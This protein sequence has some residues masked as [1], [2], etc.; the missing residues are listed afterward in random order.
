MKLQKSKSANINYL[1]K[2]VL[3]D[4]FLPHPNPEYTK[5]KRAIVD[6]FSIIVS[7]D[8]E[9]GFYVYFP[10]LSQINPDLL[11]YLS[12]YKDK[13]LNKN[14]EKTGFFEQNGR[15]KAIKLGGSPSEGFL[16][17]LQD[18]KNWIMDSVSV[19]LKD[20]EL[21]QEFDEAEH[22]GKHFWISKKYVVAQN[23][24]KNSIEE[25]KN[26]RNNKLKRFNKLIDG[27]FRFHYDTVLYRKEPYAI[28]PSDLIHIS[29]KW[30]GTSLIAS[31]IL[32]KHPRTWKDKLIM[33]IAEL[34]RVKNSMYTLPDSYPVY[35]YVYSSRTVI[36]NSNINLGV[37]EGFYNVD[38]WKYGFESLKPY[39]IKGMTMYA[40]IVGFLPNGQYI[41]K[42]YDYGCRAPRPGEEYKYNTHYKVVVYRITLTNEDGV[43]Y[44]FSPREV[45]LYCQKVGIIPVI[46][47]YYGYAKDLYPDL[48]I[49]DNWQEQFLE[50]LAN[51]KNF[52]MEQNS[53]DC[54]NNVPHEGIVIK[55]DD[56]I[57]RAWKLKCYNFLNKEQMMLDKGIENIEDIV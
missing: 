52:F 14:P 32:C 45:Q 38:V 30:H 40:E 15:V 9:N 54:A 36:K 10:A 29:S 21:N 42:S 34:F 8:M 33:K 50:R 23:K 6:G 18:L 51:D 53:P 28:E 12:L 44:E 2:I 37:S 57:P 4:K 13:N 1:S 22:N 3:I 5:L 56:G 55:K 24:R 27:Q 17:P 35:D 7:T 46:E 19:E 48:I 16:L 39:L 49:D 25:K 26:Y 43:V 41:Q 20:V 47:F 31:Y 11:S